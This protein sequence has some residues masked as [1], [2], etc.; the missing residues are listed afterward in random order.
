MAV[1]FILRTRANPN[2]F[3]HWMLKGLNCPTVDSALICSG[4]FQENFRNS[5][6]ALSNDND[7]LN[8]LRG[9][10]VVTIG[11][12]NYAWLNSYRLFSQKLVSQGIGLYAF[13]SKRMKWHAK[14][15][16]LFSSCKPVFAIVGSSN[17]TRNAFSR[18]PRDLPDFNYEADVV[19]WDNK[20]SIVNKYFSSEEFMDPQG[21]IPFQYNLRYEESDNNETT[22]RKRL[23]DLIDLVGFD[24]DN[25]E[26]L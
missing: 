25:L 26:P 20:N 1:K 12:H 10:N 13:R 6:F 2:L 14:V 18:D 5:Y 22:M 4:F 21:I 11:V 15:L 16:I 8:A 19:L 17:L 3:R 24:F 23:F 9:K 7:F